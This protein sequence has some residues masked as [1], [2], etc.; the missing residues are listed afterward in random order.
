MH[1]F[2]LACLGGEVG[3]S[4]GDGMAWASVKG[5]FNAALDRL[6]Q[7]PSAPA[8]LTG[9]WV[10]VDADTRG[11]ERLVLTD[12]GGVLT[13]QAYGAC[14]PAPCDW[15]V[16]RGH[17]Y[18]ADVESKRAVA[19]SATYSFDFKSALLT[20]ALQGPLL[21]VDCYNA[22]TVG[23]PRSDYFWSGAFTR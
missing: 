23:D 16:V 15:G 10:S 8:Q 5:L 9:T 20:G 21:M 11:I 6:D 19:F 3:Q 18:A 14:Q 7:P 12:A 13:V 17:A 2:R 22:F 4:K 1:E